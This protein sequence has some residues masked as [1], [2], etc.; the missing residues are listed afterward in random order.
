MSGIKEHI[1][2][3]SKDNQKMFIKSAIEEYNQPVLWQLQEI[4]DTD[5]RW[6][7]GETAEF[8][9][10]NIQRVEMKK[11]GLALQVWVNNIKNSPIHPHMHTRVW[12]FRGR[13]VMVQ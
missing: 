13:T 6:E 10:K 3:C 2:N 12:G 8:I 5:P 7:E 9:A 11:I 1:L 4:I